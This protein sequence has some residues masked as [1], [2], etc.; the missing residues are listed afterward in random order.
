MA[1]LILC[2]SHEI[3]TKGTGEGDWRHKAGDVVP[4]QVDCDALDVAQRV[5]HGN[6]GRRG[7]TPSDFGHLPWLH[8][9]HL[10]KTDHAQQEVKYMLLAT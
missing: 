1:S 3:V 7:A 8:K 9:P 5:C 2:N 4:C 6:S 10:C